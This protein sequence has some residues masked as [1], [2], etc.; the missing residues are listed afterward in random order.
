[1]TRKRARSPDQGA[2]FTVH[3]YTGYRAYNNVP[4]VLRDG[5]HFS[6]DPS[7]LVR[8][9][10]P[11]GFEWG[12][13]GSGPSQLA[14]ALLLDNFDTDTALDHYHDYKFGIVAGFGGEWTTDSLEIRRWLQ[15][16]MHRISQ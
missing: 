11:T 9:H 3:S 1:M 10:S 5:K 6:P 2:L 7:L 14:L 16:A 8:N 4:V 13:S 12:Y 15:Q